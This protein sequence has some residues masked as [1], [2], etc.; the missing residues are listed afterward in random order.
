MTLPH[1]AIGGH[2]P[3]V[4]TE[5]EPAPA[6]ASASSDPGKIVWYLFDGE[7][8]NHGQLENR[9]AMLKPRDDGE[10]SSLHGSLNSS[11]GFVACDQ[12][13][14]F[15]DG[16]PFSLRTISGDISLKSCI[17]YSGAV[18]S[19]R[20]AITI[21]CPG[22]LSTV[23]GDVQSAQGEV[24]LRDRAGVT[25]DLRARWVE[26]TGDADAKRLLINAADPNSR[27]PWGWVSLSGPC[28][29]RSWDFSGPT[30]LVLDSVVRGRLPDELPRHVEL[31]DTDCPEDDAELARR[32]QLPSAQAPY[33]TYRWGR[34]QYVLSLIGNPDAPG[35]PTDVAA[36]WPD[37]AR[38]AY[39]QSAELL[40]TWL[41]S[42]PDQ[43]AGAFGRLDAKAMRRTIDALRK[44]AGSLVGTPVSDARARAL[45]A[46][47]DAAEEHKLHGGKVW[48]PGSRMLLQGKNE[49]RWVCPG[50]IWRVDRPIGQGSGTG[51][52][53]DFAR[54]RRQFTACVASAARRADWSTSRLAEV[55]QALT[56]LENPAFLDHLAAESPEVAQAWEHEWAMGADQLAAQ[57]WQWLDTSPLGMLAACRSMDIRS[58]DAVV[59]ALCR[60]ALRPNAGGASLASQSNLALIAA[61]AER[62]GLPEW[63]RWVDL[64]RSPVDP[65]APTS[66][67]WKGEDSAEPS[68]PLPQNIEGLRALLATPDPGETPLSDESWARVQSLLRLLSSDALARACRGKGTPAADLVQGAFFKVANLTLAWMYKEPKEFLRRCKALD[69]PSIER[70]AV[71]VCWSAIVDGV[72]DDGSPFFKTLDD[73][74]ETARDKHLRAYRV[75]QLLHRAE[76]RNSAG[77]PWEGVT[78]RNGSAWDTE[79]FRLPKAYLRIAVALGVRE[80]P[81]RT[82]GV[83]A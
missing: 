33:S 24:R 72:S 59:S 65:E 8:H 16:S 57:L 80:D 61:L 44:V 4:P 7:R 62:R 83:S 29:V 10:R 39:A 50:E 51:G 53:E 6:L 70:M 56:Q 82:D 38:D 55:A 35:R 79:S 52:V 67:A 3:V 76:T 78:K 9:G 46:M 58:L 45:A 47:Q 77:T 75:Q 13:T 21:E 20:G 14:I 48:L 34:L 74:A 1:G 49:P 22:R 63:Q 2:V 66:R 11:S 19:G 54:T 64:F 25:G 37:K 42:A 43:V 40:W 36:A 68:E 30:T 41:D 12:T 71:P 60:H 32:L 81:S 26:L 31:L 73:F 18:L 15:S 69:R 23:Y 5:Q 27:E 17:V 28:T